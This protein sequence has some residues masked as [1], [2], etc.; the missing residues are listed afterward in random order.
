MRGLGD[1]E[2]ESLADIE[3][4]SSHHAVYGEYANRASRPG[5]QVKCHS[6][7]SPAA[8]KNAEDTIRHMLAGC[9]VPLL[10]RMR[11]LNAGLAI[12][13]ETQQTWDIPEFRF[14]KWDSGMAAGSCC[15]V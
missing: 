14:H 6:C 9:P 7:V 12:I 3:A 11:G 5:L 15:V 2:S 13:G 1:F 10:N 4:A 8:V